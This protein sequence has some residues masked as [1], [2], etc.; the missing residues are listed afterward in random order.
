M[1][2]DPNYPRMMFRQPGTEEMH[3]AKFATMIVESEEDRDRATEFG[4]SLSTAEAVE[5]YKAKQDADKK[6]AE[7]EPAT[8]AELMAKAA[9]LKLKVNA[10]D[11][12]A[13]IAAAIEA[14]L[15]A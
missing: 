6:A 3:G 11:T 10:A 12:E 5:R 9:E 4:W 8:R 15:K 1:S 13:V 2:Q 14:K 7:A